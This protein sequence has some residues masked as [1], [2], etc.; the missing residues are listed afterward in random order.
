M[1][2]AIKFFAGLPTRKV[3]RS[4]TDEIITSSRRFP[5]PRTTMYKIHNLNSREWN[6]EYDEVQNTK[7]R[8]KN[9]LKLPF[10]YCVHICITR[11]TDNYNNILN[12]F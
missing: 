9:Y 3:V 11:L 7:T 6:C 12:G 2:D 5:T 1:V 8:E 10:S 4:E